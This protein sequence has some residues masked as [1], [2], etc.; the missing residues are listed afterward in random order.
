MK[1]SIVGCL[2]L[3]LLAAS[4]NTKNSNRAAET[5]DQTEKAGRELPVN[6][7]RFADKNDTIRLQLV[8]V[9]GSI[10][11]TLVYKLHEKDKNEGTIQGTLNGD[12][13]VAD[14]TFRSEGVSSVRQVA[15][16]KI[17]NVYVE[18]YGETISTNN[19]EHF[20]NVDSL[21]YNSNFGLSEIDC[22]K[23]S[24]NTD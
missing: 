23:R 7:Y 24:P 20:R 19:R 12:I 8:R 9:G 17:N 6:C 16:K 10:T 3:Y 4:C 15:F 11:G 22:Q 14:Y 5:A 1:L 2:I 13:L 21:Q 18:G